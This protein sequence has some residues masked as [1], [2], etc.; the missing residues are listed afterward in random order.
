MND[1]VRL[2][3]KMLIM[4]VAH[5]FYTPHVQKQISHQKGISFKKELAFC[6]EWRN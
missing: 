4:S 5:I 6:E 2:L 3:M 1:H